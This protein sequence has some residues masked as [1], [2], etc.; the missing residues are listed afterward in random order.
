M[1]P[2]ASGAP[3]GRDGQAFWP[4]CTQSANVFARRVPLAYRARQLAW[5]DVDEIHDICMSALFSVP[6]RPTRA[7][8]MDPSRVS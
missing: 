8:T 6:L 1:R 4:L 2:E 5:Q 7:V 3:K